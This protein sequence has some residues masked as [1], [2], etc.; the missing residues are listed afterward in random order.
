M[1]INKQGLATLSRSLKTASTFCT[2]T[3][4]V[5]TPIFSLPPELIAPKP[6]SKH[7]PKKIDI[8]SLAMLL[9]F[10]WFKTFPFQVIL[11]NRAVASS[12]W[13]W[14][15]IYLLTCVLGLCSSVSL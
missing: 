11:L 2:M 3:P 6:L 14:L 13:W 5:G 15:L 12:G 10:M 7:D 9:W 8:F 1:L 4:G